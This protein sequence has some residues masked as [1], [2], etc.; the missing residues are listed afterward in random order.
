MWLHFLLLAL[1]SLYL[2]FLESQSNLDQTQQ[3]LSSFFWQTSFRVICMFEQSQYTLNC[4]LEFCSCARYLSWF[5]DV[6]SFWVMTL[7]LFFSKLFTVHPNSKNIS[8]LLFLVHKF[9]IVAFLVFWICM[10]PWTSYLC[11]RALYYLS[12][13][14]HYFLVLSAL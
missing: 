6:C 5:H 4:L 11:F 1:I 10:T 7:S 8:L 13:V 9:A 14:L 2:W 3:I 12:W